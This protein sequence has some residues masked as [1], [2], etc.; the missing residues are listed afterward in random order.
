[1]E[2]FGLWA[3]SL[4]LSLVP[5]FMPYMRA[6]TWLQV[7]CQVFSRLQQKALLPPLIGL[8]NNMPLWHNVLFRNKMGHTYYL[9]K[10]V[11]KGVLRADLP[12]P[13]TWPPFIVW[14]SL[15]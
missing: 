10:L 15:M 11:Q 12:L 13:S 14:Q 6:K 1:M 8:P 5:A 9:P 7:S 4:G 2:S 3:P